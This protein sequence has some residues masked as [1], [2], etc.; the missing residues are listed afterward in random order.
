MSEQHD[1]LSQLYRKV[2]PESSPEGLDQR[3]LAE[4]S[5][6]APRP[7]HRTPTWLPLASAASIVGLAALLYY[8][9]D[10]LP[11]S[12]SE[13]VPGPVAADALMAEGEAPPP[14]ASRQAVPTVLA[15]RERSSQGSIVA[16]APAEPALESIAIAAEVVDDHAVSP[17]TWLEN[18]AELLEKIG[19]AHV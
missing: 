14:V 4:A 10:S 9:T 1:D 11:I 7:E 2:A 16:A 19:R 17:A 8:Q 12:S 5:E 6:R 18:I 13:S 15:Q 3:V